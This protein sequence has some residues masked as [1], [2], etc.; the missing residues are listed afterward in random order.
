MG[1]ITWFTWDI[2]HLYLPK[3]RVNEKLRN[4]L[5]PTSKVQ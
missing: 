4:A 5:S 2:G 1:K 3:Y